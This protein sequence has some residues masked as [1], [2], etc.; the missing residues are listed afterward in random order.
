MTDQSLTVEQLTN[1]IAADIASKLNIQPTVFMERLIKSLTKNLGDKLVKSNLS[2]KNSAQTSSE[3]TTNTK[4]STTNQPEPAAVL[5]KFE[6]VQQV[7]IQA[8]NSKALDSLGD[9]L[10]DILP[11]AIAEGMKGF[12][13]KLSNL[14]DSVEKSAGDSGGLVGSLLSGLADLSILFGGKGKGLSTAAKGLRRGGPLARGLVQAG[15]GLAGIKK[16]PLGM[17]GKIGGG[18]LGTALAGY[19]FMSRKEE[20]QTTT[21]AAVGTGAGVAGGI[22]GAAIGQV[23]IP[24]PVVGAAIGGVVGSMSASWLADKM[25]GVGKKEAAA[26][27]TQHTVDDRDQHEKLEN[28]VQ[29]TGRYKSVRE[30]ISA[31]KSGKETPIVWNPKTKQYEA[32]FDDSNKNKPKQDSVPLDIPKEV[33]PTSPPIVPKEVKTAVDKQNKPTSPA[34]D[35]K[36]AIKNLRSNGFKSLRDLEKAEADGKFPKGYVKDLA[37]LFGPANLPEGQSML[38]GFRGL[39]ILLQREALTEAG[40]SSGLVKNGVLV[41]KND[42]ETPT[43][44]PAP[45][46]I[47]KKIQ[48][49]VDEQNKPKR[50]AIPSKKSN[51]GTLPNKDFEKFAEKDYPK[52]YEKFNKAKEAKNKAYEGFVPFIPFI[53]SGPTSLQMKQR[54]IQDKAREKADKEYDELVQQKVF[55]HK[56]FLSKQKKA[57]YADQEVKGQQQ[58][59]TDISEMEAGI[60]KQKDLQQKMSEAFKTPTPIKDGVISNQG[61]E[62]KT[63]KGALFSADPSDVG[64]FGTKDTFS[65]LGELLKKNSGSQSIDNESLKTT[66][67]EAK[68]TN[69]KLTNLT[70]GFNLLARALEKMGANIGEKVQTPTIINASSGNSSASQ[71]QVGSAQYTGDMGS[72][73]R[74]F[75]SYAQGK[76]PR[77]H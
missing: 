73:A 67:N 40:V 60:K 71:Q 58:V 56:M 65:E 26:K 24:I 76:R 53:E 74:A 62:I 43:T 66:A 11:K 8:F 3:T 7:E 12:S 50:E 68:V 72:P 57:K 70:N 52:F 77:T 75:T 33:K 36:E 10:T 18:V 47:P 9:K 21:Q 45:P 19:N 6:D 49:A 61:L 23:L 13:K 31:V 35:K 38:M 48:S 1:L 32:S 4:R 69:E 16:L 34:F 44:S 59:N 64:V 30:F 2:I 14:A 29:S 28:Y 63:S 27:K 37:K 42:K 41:Q 46:V 20:G 39:D 5:E 51:E 55:L 22:A 17:A 25:T 54:D 15:S